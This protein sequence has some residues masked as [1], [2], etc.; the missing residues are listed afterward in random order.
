MKLETNLQGRLR[1]TRLPQSKGL[2]PL[3]EA[4]IN[5]I[6][7]L[8]AAEIPQDEKVIQVIIQREGTPLFDESSNASRTDSSS[9]EPI[10][11]FKVLDTGIGFGEDNFNSFKTLDSQYKID[12]GGRGIGRL[13][14]L[15]AFDR[16]DVVSY[17]LSDQHACKKRSF[18]FSPDGISDHTIIDID[19]KVHRRTSVH[20]RGFKEHFRSSTPKKTSAI[21]RAIVEYCL[22]Y[23]VRPGGAPRIEVSDGDQEIL[24]NDLYENLMYS[25]A[26]FDQIQIKDTKFDLLHVKLKSTTSAI[27]S[28]GYCADK[29]LVVNEKL[30]KYVHGLHGK[31]TNGE[32]FV[33]MCY[34]SSELLNERVDPVRNMFDINP[35]SGGLFDETEISWSEISQGVVTKISE[36]LRGYIDLINQRVQERLHQFVTAKAPRYRPILGYLNL[37]ELNIDPEGSDRDI[38]LALHR[39][40]ADM[41]SQLLTEGQ[42]LMNP[43]NGETF[44]DY[45]DRIGSY[46]RKVEDVK[47][48]DLANYVTHRR[49][50]LDLL[51]VAIERRSDGRYEHEELIH[52]LMMPMQ[53][54]SSEVLQDH[55]NLWL[56]DERLAFHEYLASDKRLSAMPIT[57]STSGK[58]PDILALNVFDNPILISDSRTPPLASIVIVELKRPMR[59]DAAQGVEKDPI[60]QALMYLN[61]TRKGGVKTVHGR[62]IPASANIPGFCYVICDITPTIEQRCNLHNLSRTSDDM[63]YFGYNKNYEAYLEVISFDR[64]VNMAMERNRAFFDKLGLPAG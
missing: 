4:I 64:L 18:H 43:Q 21:A 17:F 48:S 47:K 28:I 12:K 46:L 3:F 37:N 49:V 38:E 20:L 11:N 13:L 26:E 57:G 51:R 52:K 14:W 35:D 15:K 27:H 36:H 42:D 62:Q 45:H 16:V 59:N 60:E 58:E 24:L 34:V 1:N 40:Y 41:E 53:M 29:R 7:G 54:E 39:Q 5:S 30:S 32:K 9:I 6:H 33:Y 50:V 10:I 31:I 19:D 25:S 23:F 56:I 8:E 63:G 44:E 55:C 22:W 61:E 2:F